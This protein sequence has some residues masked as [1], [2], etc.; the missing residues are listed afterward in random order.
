MN[1]RRAFTLV[2][3]LVAVGITAVLAA[4]LLGLVSRTVTLWDR[5]AS[6]L[7]LEND[8]GLMLER[9]VRDLETAYHSNQPAGVEWI[10]YSQSNDVLDELRLISMGAASSHDEGAPNTLREVT[11][12]LVSTTAGG[13][14]YRMEGD[15]EDTLVTN[16]GWL[17][18]PEVPDPEFLL[19]SRVDELEVTFWDE[20]RQPIL[21][22]NADNWP[23]LVKIELRLL[24]VHGAF[25]L[26]AVQDGRSNESEDQIR[27]EA[28]RTFVRWVAMGGAFR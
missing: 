20:S 15:A 16:Y 4:V 28:S 6:A 12:Q 11:Y 17:T 26:Q 7:V 23:Y 27:A 14:L 9:L 10:A 21:G 3:L 24:T 13:K 8:A 25:R 1:S 19:A 18:W 2:E 22:V 5:S